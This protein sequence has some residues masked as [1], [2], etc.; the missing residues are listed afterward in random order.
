[1]INVA[2]AAGRLR[3]SRDKTDAL[4]SDELT[5]E[6]LE[7]LMRDFVR[8]AE[9]GAHEA[10]GWP[11]TCYGVSKMGVIAMTRVMA[12]MEPALMFSAVDPGYCKT[13]QNNNRGYVSPERGAET[14]A[15]LAALPAERFRSGALWFEEKE[16]RW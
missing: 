1:M 15:M 7:E 6:A 8:D 5:M 3:G 13:D 2:S 4:S 9:A 12:R 10:R 11:N 14:A 16:I